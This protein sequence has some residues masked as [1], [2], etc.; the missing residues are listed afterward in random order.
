[1]KINLLTDA[2]RHNLA[3]R[4]RGIRNKTDLL[5]ALL[6]AGEPSNVRSSTEVAGITRLGKLLF[7]LKIEEGLLHNVS[8]ENDF[9]FVPF[10][11]GPWTNEVYD[12]VDFLEALGLLKKRS[13][14]KRSAADVAHDD[15]LFDAAILDKYQQDAACI[16][17]NAEVFSLTE[18]GR[19]KART[20]WNRL[21]DK[22]KQKIM[23]V[24]RKFNNMN[25]KQFLRYVYKMYPEYASESEIKDYLR[26]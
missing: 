13:G 23:R 6:Y 22:E 5:L 18:K 21:S 24:K 10:R 3:L 17:Q 25:L 7:L 8:Q 11:M 14:G 16:D 15:E 9:N 19:E 20:I 1:M 2:K 12:E 26:C 4:R